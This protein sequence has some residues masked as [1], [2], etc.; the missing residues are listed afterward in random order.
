MA[1]LLSAF[2][3]ANHITLAEH[4]TLEGTLLER[5]IS[6][7][8]VLKLK[9]YNEQLQRV[10]EFLKTLRGSGSGVL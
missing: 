1:D 4:M 3:S 6:C 5:A 2:F 7:K 10:K 8:A 9:N